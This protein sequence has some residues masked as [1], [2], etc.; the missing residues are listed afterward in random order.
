MEKSSKFNFVCAVGLLAM[1]GVGIDQAV[2][3]IQKGDLEFPK[4]WSA[5]HTGKMTQTIEKQIDQKLPIRSDLIAFANSIRYRLLWAGGEQV[6][7]G[8]EGWLFL[9]DELKYEGGKRQVGAAGHGTAATFAEND[10]VLALEER[11][12]LIAQLNERLSKQG[13]KL[14]I[15]L[16]PDKARVY[17]DKLF[18]G[19][20]PSYNRDKYAVALKKL[21]GASVTTVDLYEP[22]KTGR[23]S[24]DT[25]YTSDTHWN[26]NG[27]LLA[28]QAI[29]KQVQLLKLDLAA[30]TFKTGPSVEA[31]QAR[32]GDLIRLMG[33]E[34]MPSALKP[35]VDLEQTVTTK[36]E[37]SGGGGL[38]GEA[39]V[40]VTLAGT[41]YSLRG[42]FHG[43]LQQTIGSTV[44]NTAKDGG[45]FLQAMTAYLNDESFKANKPKLLIWEIPERMLQSPIGEEKDWLKQFT[46]L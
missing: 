1:L 35:P 38:F 41:S 27:A 31:K 39:S 6:R 20:Y 14:L 5:F 34:G 10:P 25:Y 46:A 24:S 9:T 30:A 2:K 11:V 21:N 4:G 36:A 32:S 42:N 26:Q 16:V 19:V 8:K 17:E 12:R 40:P 23:A 3:T 18:N 37:G 29:A 33:L 43:Y 13:V 15:A 44:L 22:L 7:V 45:G 28:S